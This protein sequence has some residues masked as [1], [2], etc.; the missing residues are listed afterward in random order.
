MER[1]EVNNTPILEPYVFVSQFESHSTSDCSSLSLL[2]L[3]T[4]TRDIEYVPNIQAPSAEELMSGVGW[5]VEYLLIWTIKPPQNS[6]LASTLIPKT[7]KPK[8]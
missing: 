1:F 8:P 7:P 2:I 4:P 6:P 3:H 5:S